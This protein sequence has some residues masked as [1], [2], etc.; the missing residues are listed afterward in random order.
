MG[1]IPGP[2]YWVKGIGVAAAASYVGHSCSS[3]LIPGRGTS[4]C[5]G[6]SHFKKVVVFNF[7]KNIK[8]M[9]KSS[10]AELQAYVEVPTGLAKGRMAAWDGQPPWRQLHLQA[11]WL[12]TCLARGKAWSGFCAFSIYVLLPTLSVGTLHQPKILFF[13][14]IMT[15]ELIK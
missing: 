15:D 12:K 6:C 1:S 9:Q 10:C 14:G 8:F 5:C 2:G 7:F 11:G 13:R 4:I 3:D